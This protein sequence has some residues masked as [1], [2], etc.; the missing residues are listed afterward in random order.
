MSTPPEVLPHRDAIKE[1]LEGVG[2][3]VGLGVA[4]DPAPA[5]GLYAVLYMSPGQTMSESLADQRT[6]MQVMFQVTCVGADEE[7]CLWVVDK[8]RRAL[9]PR[10]EVTGRKAFRAEELGGPPMLRDDDLTP[11]VFYLPIQFMLRTI[12]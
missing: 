11:P 6:D 10:L 7:R 9:H 1:A 3:A 2:L 8:V 12:S 5:A 4:P